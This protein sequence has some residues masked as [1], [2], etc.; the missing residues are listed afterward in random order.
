MSGT[1]AIQRDGLAEAAASLL[2]SR[3]PGLI[4][5]YGPLGRAKCIEDIK[6]TALFLAEAV[7]NKSFSLFIDYIGWV[8]ILFISRGIDIEDLSESLGCMTEFVPDF[9]PDLESLQAI[10]LLKMAQERL[11]FLPTDSGVMIKENSLNNILAREY[12]S[13]LLNGD[14]RRASQAILSRVEAGMPVKEVYLDVFEP[15]LHEVGRLWHHNKITVADE[16]FVTAAT[17]S[18]MSQLYPY[19]FT[20]ASKSRSMVATCVSGELHEIGMRMVAD[21]FEMDGWD[22]FYLGASVPAK[23]VISAVRV[24]NAS[25]LGISAT[26]TRHLG[27]VI[28]LVALSRAEFGQSLIILV[29]GYP[30]NLDR[31]LWRQV[32]ADGM[33]TDATS[34][35][36]SVAT[37]EAGR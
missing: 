31:D 12:L 2:Y 32:G 6:Q 23:D 20:G 37:I 3:K 24:R 14:K 5:R 15:I 19:I 21:C 33:A 28:E 7:N 35:V 8:K 25:V 34:A 4:E 9:F 18:I 17:Q 29:G 10:A 26:L 27:Q 30:F 1:L 36:N 16:H 22:S 11:A 13:A